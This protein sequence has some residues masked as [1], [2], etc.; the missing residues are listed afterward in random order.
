MLRHFSSLRLCW[1][2][3]V[4]DLR[5]IRLAL[6]HGVPDRE[7]RRPNPAHRV[8]DRTISICNA[9]A[10]PSDL[11]SAIEDALDERK[12]VTACASGWSPE[13]NTFDESMYK[14]R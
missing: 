12:P 6:L 7:S 4:G 14:I 9:E 2:N 3:Y 13:Q 11:V 8:I 10:H 1:S 5:K